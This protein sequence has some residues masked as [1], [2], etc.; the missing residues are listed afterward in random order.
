MYKGSHSFY[1]IKDFHSPRDKRDSGEKDLEESKK[2]K[3]KERFLW[4]HPKQS[5]RRGDDV[6]Y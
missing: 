5:V 1:K 6:Y 2:E 4:F 3:N